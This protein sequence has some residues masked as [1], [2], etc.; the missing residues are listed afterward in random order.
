MEYTSVCLK[1]SMFSR[2]ILDSKTS[3]AIYLAVPTYRRRDWGELTSWNCNSCF[4][5]HCDLTSVFT[6]TVPFDMYPKIQAILGTGHISCCQETLALSWLP[7]YLH[8][9]WWGKK[10]VLFS[11]L[12]K[13][14]SHWQVFLLFGY[15]QINSDLW[16][17]SNCCWPSVFQMSKKHIVWYCTEY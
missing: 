13:Q 16:A 12:S 14:F 7:T 5:F 10:I 3:G 17:W 8:L 11:S 2:F 9:S 1:D 15:S 6:E 4:G